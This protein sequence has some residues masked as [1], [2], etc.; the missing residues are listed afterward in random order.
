MFQV[1]H[2]SRVDAQLQ[3][4]HLDLFFRKEQTLQQ[5]DDPKPNTFYIAKE[6]CLTEAYD[7][8]LEF[9]YDRYPF[10]LMK[11]KN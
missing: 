1:I 4:C 8:Y 11:F 2:K 9:E 7:T 6:A 10:V 3:S 5:R